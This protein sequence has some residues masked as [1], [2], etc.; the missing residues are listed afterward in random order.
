MTCLYGKYRARCEDVHDPELLGRIRVTCPA[1]YGNEWSD[2]AYPNFPPG[3]FALPKEGDLV[4]VEFEGG[5][6]AYPIWTGIWYERGQAP[7]QELHEPLTNRD[8]IEVDKDKREMRDHA[9]DRVEREKFRQGL[10]YDPTKTVIFESETGITIWIDDTPTQDGGLY[11]EDRAGNTFRIRDNGKNPIEFEDMNGNRIYTTET[12]IRLINGNGHSI[13]I[14]DNAVFL[15]E[16]KGGAYVAIE[17]GLITFNA[18]DIVY[19]TGANFQP[20]IDDDRG[21]PDVTKRPMTFFWRGMACNTDPVAFEYAE[22]DKEFYDS[23]S[24]IEEPSHD[25]YEE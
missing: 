12:G 21:T 19:N 8:G 17:G 11:I 5:K 2:W 22:E 24:P 7:R 1:V 15:H 13:E 4:W 14:D 16:N 18:S 6:P 25:D 3:S 9:L 23:Y 20:L 10:H